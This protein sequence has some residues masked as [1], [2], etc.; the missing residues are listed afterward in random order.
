MGPVDCAGE[1]IFERFF[2]GLW[3]RKGGCFME[4]KT[5]IDFMFSEQVEK[6]RGLSDLFHDS[7]NLLNFSQDGAR[8]ISFIL[9]DMAEDISRLAEELNKQ[10]GDPETEKEI[11]EFKDT[12]RALLEELMRRPDKL[13]VCKQVCELT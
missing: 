1:K 6:L 13:R 10:Y 11:E 3:A 2:Y 8:G 9:S 12:H 5:R 4:E 7:D